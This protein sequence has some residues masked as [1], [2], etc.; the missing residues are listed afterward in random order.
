MR[1]LI[2]ILQSSVIKGR[3]T[4]LGQNSGHKQSQLSQITMLLRIGLNN[5]KMTQSTGLQVQA[6]IQEDH[7]LNRVVGLLG[8]DIP[9]D[10][11][12]ITYIVSIKG[13]VKRHVFGLVHVVAIGFI[14]QYVLLGNS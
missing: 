4:D 7:Q 10:F 12:A 3:G 9:E 14:A 8:A 5:N 13:I 2:Q 11:D 1:K 6:E